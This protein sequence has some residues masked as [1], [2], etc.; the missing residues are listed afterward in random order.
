MSRAQ[1]MLLAEFPQ[2]PACSDGA[3]YSHRDAHPRRRVRPDPIRHALW[4]TN[5]ENFIEEGRYA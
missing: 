5:F 1:Q 3:A 2:T 4:Y